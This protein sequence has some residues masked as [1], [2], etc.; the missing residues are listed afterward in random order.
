MTKC[1]CGHEDIYHA[2]PENHVSGVS[3]CT[4]QDCGCK[5]FVKGEVKQK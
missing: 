4:K 3:H 5:E 2:I 1:K